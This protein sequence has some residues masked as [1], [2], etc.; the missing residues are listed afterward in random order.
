[1]Y[2]F[3]ISA[4]P[5]LLPKL[6]PKKIDKVLAAASRLLTTRNRCPVTFKL[7]YPNPIMPLPEGTPTQIG[8]EDQLEA[9]H[10]VTACGSTANCYDVKIVERI[11]F[12]KTAKPGY[13]GCAWRHPGYGRKTV[14]MTYT[15]ST[16][17]IR[18]IAWAHEFGHT[19][20]LQH[21]D[22]SSGALMTQCAMDG[23]TVQVT[24]DECNCFRAGPG[25]NLAE[26]SKPDPNL[27]CSSGD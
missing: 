12:C 11:S 17:G 4:A 5:S 6:N 27:T 19:T 8:S 2:T 1:V 9:V 7:D 10:R 13:V 20:G 3:K 25:N 26:C 15:A 14:I 16:A 21:R 23:R 22:D 18:H 24:P